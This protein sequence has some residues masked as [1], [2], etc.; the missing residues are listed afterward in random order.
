MSG[1]GHRTSSSGVSAG[2][3]ASDPFPALRDDDPAAGAF[4]D[5]PEWDE[6]DLVLRELDRLTAILLRQ[7][8]EAETSVPSAAP[9]PH[10]G[11]AFPALYLGERIDRANQATM[12][13]GRAVERM[14]P[15]PESI[16]RQLATIRL[17]LG[18]ARQELDFLA[19]EV[20]FGFEPRKDLSEWDGSIER[21]PSAPSP[22]P[23]RPGASVEGPSGV[24]AGS[25]P[26]FTAERYHR[27][28]AGMVSR[29]G[30]LLAWTL[31]LSIGITAALEGLN[32]WAHEPFPATWLLVILPLVWLIPVPFF[33]L[34][35]IGAQRTLRWNRLQTD[36]GP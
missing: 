2:P 10:P 20:G 12:E 6:S 16:E 31:A 25:Y 19:D 17:E 8:A 27:A 34:S 9:R 18:R 22:V 7:R 33:V 3:S 28:V 36:V 13:L 4:A 32:L 14:G 21:L 5:V 26:A 24:P 15:P 30:R 35:F 1:E 23:P 29:R 11:R